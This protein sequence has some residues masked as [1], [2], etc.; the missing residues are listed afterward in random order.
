MKGEGQF[1]GSFISHIASALERNDFDMKNTYPSSQTKVLQTIREFC[2]NHRRFIRCLFLVLCGFVIAYIMW[3]W[4]PFSDYEDE[5]SNLNHL[6]ILTG[7]AETL[8]DVAT[9][10]VALGLSFK[11]MRKSIK[12]DVDSKENQGTNSVVMC[13]GIDK[14]NVLDAMNYIDNYIQKGGT[15][16]GNNYLDSNRL[17][18]YKSID[19]VTSDKLTEESIEEESLVSET[20]IIKNKLEKFSKNAVLSN[21]RTYSIKVYRCHRKKNDELCGHYI[22][23]E[24]DPLEN[25]EQVLQDG[26]YEI[27]E[28]ITKLC[29]KY[30]LN[31]GIREIHL[32]YAGPLSFIFSLQHVLSEFTVC[33]YHYNSP[34]YLLTDRLSPLNGGGKSEG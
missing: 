19:E 29:K 4:R 10:S 5:W 7:L 12:W 24:A 31:N 8:V 16:I 25:T 6:G 30:F 17:E 2:N 15:L 14:R 28:T 32:F 9:F 13:V 22:A 1:G 18:I 21:A 20:G 27:K 23:I 3:K 33:I 34:E 11:L 26:Y